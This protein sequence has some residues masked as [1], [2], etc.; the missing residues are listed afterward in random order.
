VKPR[1]RHVAFLGCAGALLAACSDHALNE[2][3]LHPVSLPGFSIDLPE[4]RVT[5]TTKEA[6]AGRHELLLPEPGVLER[7][8]LTTSRKPVATVLV[9]WNRHGLDDKDIHGF[10]RGVALNS[11][12]GS[13]VL[14]ESRPTPQSW[15]LA[16][17][18]PKDSVVYAFHSCEPGFGVVVVVNVNKRLDADFGLASK[19]IQTVTCSLTE[20]NRRPP[21]VATRLPREFARVMGEKDPLF[22]SPAGEA[23]T[24][25]FGTG[26]IPG[27]PEFPVVMRALISQT[28][29]VAPEQPVI[30]E[31]AL[32]NDDDRQH[33]L[34]NASAGGGQFHVGVLWCPKLRVTVVATY[35]SSQSSDERALQVF[36][37]IYCPG[38]PGES[39][40]DAKPIFEAACG[41]G[42]SFACESLRTHSF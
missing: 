13:K 41:A 2:P 7:L 14:R 12:P 36:D 11:I 30:R 23:L 39:P 3:E 28:P 5:N 34:V 16:V 40:P 24:I 27:S 31:I 26:D 18:V 6:F 38:E 32:P 42:N 37:S 35:L 17:G 29:G 1:T 21:E 22:L 20:A 8:P 19:I 4:G 9:S 15:V 10:L 25:G 33:R